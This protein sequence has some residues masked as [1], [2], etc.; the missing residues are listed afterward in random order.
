MLSRHL[1][2]RTGHNRKPEPLVG[3]DESRLAQDTEKRRGSANPAK[4][5]LLVADDQGLARLN[6]A[7]HR[8][9][10]GASGPSVGVL[11]TPFPDRFVH[12]DSSKTTH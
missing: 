10:S 5:N 1:A 11:Q 6:A 4:R 9:H 2:W 12:R 3:H 8:R 7:T